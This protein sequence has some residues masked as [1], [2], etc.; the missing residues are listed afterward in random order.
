MAADGS[1]GR[2]ATGADAAAAL[3]R[4]RLEEYAARWERSSAKLR[5]GEYRADDLVEDCFTLWGNALRDVT[6]M[7]TLTWQARPAPRSGRAAPS[8]PPR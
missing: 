8:S 1:A 4:R 6:A 7:A 3:A 5:R 2:Q